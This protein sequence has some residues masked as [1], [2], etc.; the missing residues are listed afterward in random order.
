[1]KT[2]WDCCGWMICIEC[3]VLVGSGSFGGW[4]LLASIVD[5]D[6]VEGVKK[7]GHWKFELGLKKPYA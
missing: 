6:G 2:P 4:I 1:M 7:L 5:C 3:G